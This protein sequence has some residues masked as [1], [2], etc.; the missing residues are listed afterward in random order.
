[1]TQIE[2][3]EHAFNVQQKISDFTQSDERCVISKREKFQRLYL[4]DIY[5]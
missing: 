1:M 5:S 2:F 4:I 3:E